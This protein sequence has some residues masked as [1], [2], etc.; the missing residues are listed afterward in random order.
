M[1]WGREMVQGLDGKDAI[2]SD[3]AELNKRTSLSW[4]FGIQRHT[5]EFTSFLLKTFYTFRWFDFEKK[6]L[7]RWKIIELNCSLATW[8]QSL[9]LYRRPCISIMTVFHTWKV[10]FGHSVSV[11]FSENVE[12]FWLALFP[13]V[14]CDS[15][16]SAQIYSALTYD[17]VQREKE[18]KTAVPVSRTWQLS[19][20][21]IGIY[22]RCSVEPA[23]E[24]TPPSIFKKAGRQFFHN[25]RETVTIVYSWLQ[26]TVIK[27]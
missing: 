1:A 7:K 13:P 2:L 20:Q 24:R 19:S 21:L 12:T 15:L 23:L 5:V 25:Y 16:T 18:G 10:S 26:D 3:W 9:S 14:L 27:I 22:N 4:A 11:F 6:I 17:T 8:P